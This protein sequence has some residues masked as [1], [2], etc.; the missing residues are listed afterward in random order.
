MKKS[1]FTL[2]ALGMLGVTFGQTKSSGVITLGANSTAIIELDNSNSTVKLT[3][4][5]PSNG[6]FALGF[7]ASGMVAGT[8]VVTVRN[9]NGLSDD[10]IPGTAAPVIDAKQNW[11]VAPNGN[12]V[13]GTTRTILATRAFNTGDTNDYIFDYNSTSINLI[14]ASPNSSSFTPAYHGSAHGVSHG[15]VVASFA[16]LGV[17]DFASPGAIEVYPNPSKN[18]VFSVSKNNSIS[19]S[20]IKVFDTS[21]KLLKSI[22]ASKT[23]QTDNVDLNGFAKGIYFME[24]TNS[25]DKTVK[26]IIIE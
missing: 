3:L 20:K 16:T 26:K 2:L 24:L 9:A 12:T 1:Y 7:N 6:W 18:G 23:N 10:T 17:A 21:A 19:I 11:V 14:F 15:A 25:N 13:S 4:T 5:G 8:D 22:D